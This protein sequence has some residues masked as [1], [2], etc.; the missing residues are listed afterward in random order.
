M[1]NIDLQITDIQTMLANFEIKKDNQSEQ[2]EDILY[3]SE[4]LK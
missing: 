2:F 1:N 4:K 3:E